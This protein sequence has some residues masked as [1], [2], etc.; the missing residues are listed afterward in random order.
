MTDERA[1]QEVWRKP[2]FYRLSQNERN[3][4]SRGARPRALGP[5]Q[6][7]FRDENECTGCFQSSAGGR[8]LVRETIRRFAARNGAE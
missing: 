5:W 2:N 1:C 8:R 7:C 3:G 4:D 6:I